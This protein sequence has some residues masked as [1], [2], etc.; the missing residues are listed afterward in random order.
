MFV[1]FGLLYDFLKDF[2]LLYLRLIKFWI[3][4]KK[5]FLNMYLIKMNYVYELILFNFFNLER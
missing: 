3:V 2:R 4:I 1:N 5:L